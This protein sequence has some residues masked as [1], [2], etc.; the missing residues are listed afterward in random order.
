MKTLFTILFCALFL[1][2]QSQNHGNIWYFGEGAGLD[3]NSG[4]P[5]VLVDGMVFGDPVFELEFLYSEGTATISDAFG[6]LLFYSNGEQV[7][8]RDHEVMP[9][10][11]DIMGMYSSTHAAFIIPVPNR[12]SLFFLFTTDGLERDL[13][14]GLRYSLVNMC[15]DEGM[16][17]VDPEV[18]NIPLL[19]LA[20]EKLAGVRHSNGEDAW[21]I[22]HEHGTDAFYSY[23]ITEEGIDTTVISNVGS[24]HE[25]NGFYSAIGQMKP[26]PDGTKLALVVANIFPSILEVFDFDASTGVISN[27]I[28]LST[29]GG[30]YGIEFSPD[31]TNIYTQSFGGVV[32]YD[33]SAGS[34]EEID[35][36]RIQVSP[37]LCVP[38]GM[39]LG[40]DDKI[41]VNRC[42]SIISVIEFPDLPGEDC[43]FIEEGLDIDPLEARVSF[44]SFIAGYDYYHIPVQCNPFFDEEVEEVTVEETGVDPTVMT[45]IAE[46]PPAELV[47]FP[48]PFSGS[49]IVQGAGSGSR[50]Q[51]T[52]ADGKQVLSQQ[53]EGDTQIDTSNL[54]KGVYLFV[55]NDSN[56]SSYHSL[57]VK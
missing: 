32:Q 40:P 3:F 52:S 8:N 5:E 25:G 47:I 26:S 12:D 29:Y 28:S 31:G 33:L 24:V 15:L 22:A 34:A 19:D 6:D 1:T 48:N 43:G 39:Q 4:S 2:V 56:G 44:P 14:D 35:D 36:S 9:N 57:M 10:G 21:L 50:L 13:E 18:K 20:T 46:D 42:G 30:E 41:Y 45:G 55:V 17:D 51:V 54:P 11:D 53:L 27:P 49:V 7:W 23:K 37:N 16:G 38:G